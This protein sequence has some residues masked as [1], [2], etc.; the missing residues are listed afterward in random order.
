LKL[1]DEGEGG[2]HYQVI[3]MN[4]NYY[5]KKVKLGDKVNIDI[6]SFGTIG[7][8]MTYIMRNQINM[9]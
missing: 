6:K 8:L 7:H 9:S 1:S 3:I 2:T 4:S 5:M